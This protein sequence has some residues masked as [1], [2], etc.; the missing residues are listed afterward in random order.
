MNKKILENELKNLIQSTS[1]LKA[2]IARYKKKYPGQF[3]HKLM[4]SAVIKELITM[5]KMIQAQKDL[6][7]E[8]ITIKEFALKNDSLFSIL[9][10][11]GAGGIYNGIIQYSTAIRKIPGAAQ[12]ERI[13]E[14]AKE[15]LLRA[16]YVLVVCRERENSSNPPYLVSGKENILLIRW[17]ECPLC[18]W[19]GR[20]RYF[21]FS[22]WTL[23]KKC[24]ICEGN[25]GWFWDPEK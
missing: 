25:R 9:E 16:G 13:S 23:G 6:E 12:G 7:A 15:L 22:I 5:A 18:A 8:K 2:A 4:V 3:Y 1:G 11:M 17:E 21:L 14:W 19:M 20:A 24:K 10:T